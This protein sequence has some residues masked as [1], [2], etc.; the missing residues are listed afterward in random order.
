[1]Q[2]VN[3]TVKYLKELTVFALMV[4][5][6]KKLDSEVAGDRKNAQI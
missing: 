3:R 6:Y 5:K 2:K 4:L 1:M